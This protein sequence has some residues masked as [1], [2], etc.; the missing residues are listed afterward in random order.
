MSPQEKAVAACSQAA[1]AA[2]LVLA[3]GVALLWLSQP[4]VFWAP[5]PILSA[6]LS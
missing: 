5:C 6:L 3:A 4:S 2:P 1:A